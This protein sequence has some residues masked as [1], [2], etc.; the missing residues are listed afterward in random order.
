MMRK[1]EDAAVSRC[2]EE[3]ELFDKSR[4]SRVDLRNKINLEIQLARV[5][6]EQPI[7]R[8]A[9]DDMVN[10][11]TW[12]MTGPARTLV[13]WIRKTR[14]SLKSPGEPLYQARHEEPA[15]P[16]KSISKSSQTDGVNL[17]IRLAHAWSEHRRLSN[18]IDDILKSTSWRLTA[19][20]RDFLLAAK[21]TGGY[22]QLKGITANL[23]RVASLLGREIINRPPFREIKN[24]VLYL[25]DVLFMDAGVY[26]NMISMRQLA[27]KR[28]DASAWHGLQEEPS[29]RYPCID[30]GV[31]TFNNKKWLPI[32][33]SSLLAQHYPL[34]KIT[35]IVVDH[36]S[37]DGTM[38]T[39]RALED[40][41]GSRFRRFV[42]L[43]QENLGFG[44]G[45]NL[46][47]RHST[48]HY[49]LVSNVDLE[50]EP[51]AL[52][53]IVGAAT[54]EGG[55]L[56]SLEFRQ[57]PYEH[58]KY[59]DPVTLETSWS[60][61]SCVLFNSDAFAAVG[62]Y[63][64]R[65][66]MYGEDVE[67][68]YRLRDRGFSVKYCPQ[69][70]AWHY[71]YQDQEPEELKPLQLKGNTVA[72][73][74]IRIRYGAWADILQIPG[75]FV[76]LTRAR[77][78]NREPLNVVAESCWKVL[79]NFP[80]FLITRKQS[81]LVFP[82]DDWD[83]ERRREGAFYRQLRSPERCLPIVT[84]II[85]TCPGR[86][87][88]LCE[89]LQSLANQ[90]YSN[91]EIII[92]ETG[93]TTAV[94]LA[95]QFRSW[96]S[97]SI[98]HLALPA[99]GRSAAAN[100]GLSHAQGEYI[101]FLDDDAMLFSDHVETLVSGLL[102]EPDREAAYAL[103]MEIRSIYVG[104]SMSKYHEVEYV[105]PQNLRQPFD[106]AV[107]LNR[108]FI[109]TQ[110]LLF[111]R[112]LYRQ[113]GGFD[114]NLADSAEWDLWLRYSHRKDFLFIEKTTSLHRSFYRPGKTQEYE[115]SVEASA[116]L[117]RQKHE[118]P[119]FCQGL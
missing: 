87:A 107:L 3:A 100:A 114:E 93:G 115:K 104:N 70:V 112:S 7:L 99:L 62:G 35:L 94:P 97:L 38:D 27:A 65:I 16:G 119:E 50:F 25:A 2:D 95:E 40:K 46:A 61:H 118:A 85:R 43:Q 86:S 110:S 64:A 74:F 44:Q 83:F 22:R 48:A 109:P 41:Y 13:S 33:M 96:Y 18:V 9:I 108:N 6:R 4:S 117:I 55:A 73:C 58:P 54:R 31:V 32:F 71:F 53:T 51:D 29:E 37:L 52:T 5:F 75:M 39:W 56:G 101:M 17:E 81:K 36:S 98:F 20:F 30:I 14:S 72:N 47:F 77:Y 11:A 60:A 12:R 68:S 69:A 57:K 26:R 49:F 84:V 24:Q 19:P 88:Y 15:L 80:Y 23:L 102:N 105:S 89:A 76:G 91:I 90:T 8:T 82:F 34:E 66:F 67:L 10:S 111:H 1:D 28:C 59:Y 106:R 113:Y 78:R 21:K 103:S 116:H 45:Q 92:L 79:R 63:E 42:I